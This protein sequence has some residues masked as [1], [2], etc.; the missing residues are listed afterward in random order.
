LIINSGKQRITKH[1]PQFGRT[2]IFS[3]FSRYQSFAIG[4]TD[5]NAPAHFA[6]LAVRRLALVVKKI[7]RSFNQQQHQADTASNSQTAAML[8][9]AVIV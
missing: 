6:T 2:P 5:S 8:P 7:I 9:L 4:L 1:C 3:A